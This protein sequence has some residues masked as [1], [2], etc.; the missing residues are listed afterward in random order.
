MV[1]VFPE[2]NKGILSQSVRI[3][4]YSGIYFQKSEDKKD[5]RSQTYRCSPSLILLPN[6]GFVFFLIT[7]ILPYQCE[8]TEAEM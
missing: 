8:F 5:E 3:D 7:F 2:Q 1:A 6:D 4:S